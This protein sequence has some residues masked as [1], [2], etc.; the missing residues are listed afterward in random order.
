MEWLPADS[1]TSG[2]RDFRIDTGGR[3]VTGALW[4]PS[5]T[6]ADTALLLCGHGAS[7]DR[8]QRP[9][10]HIAGRFL[11]F[12]VAT[13]ALDGPVHGLRQQGPGGRAALATEI[14]RPSCIDDMVADWLLALARVR[15]ACGLTDGPLAYFGLSM[16]TLFGIPLL[17]TA[18]E[19][20]IGFRASVLGLAGTSGAADFLGERLAADAGSIEN[21]VLFL[22]QLEDELFDRAGC[23]ALFDAL[24]TTDK[25]L[26][27]NPGLHPEVPTEEVD[28]SIA[29][30]RERLW[31]DVP[32][33]ITNP[34]AE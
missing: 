8:Y 4:L 11:S 12:G 3:P 2:A 22:M 31:T 16:G 10:P 13:L 1:G 24:A 25:R 28:A 6:G 19:R 21:P 32:R 26:H 18:R 30:L 29:F 14:R 33:L 34:L 9:I 15:D 5:D 27:A 23:L 20:G 7:G 17:A